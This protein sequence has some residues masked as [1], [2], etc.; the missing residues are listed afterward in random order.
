M[1][2]K[3]KKKLCL[4]RRKIS[5][6]REI[7]VMKAFI[8]LIV[9]SFIAATGVAQSDSLQK[10]INEQVWKPFITSYNNFDTDAFMAVHSKEL[11]R[12]LQD[13]DR[14]MNYAQYLESNKRGNDYGKS[15][16]DKRT[17]E[18]RFTERIAGE[19]RAFEVGYYKVVLNNNQAV[20]AKFQV[21]LR[22]E[23]GKWK[24][25]MDADANE[26]TMENTF[27]SGKPL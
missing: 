5:T 19:G 24:I 20:Y 1:F 22:V 9:A 26:K 4:K 11:T 17:I 8:L 25:L 21:L 7:P 14:V 10:Q 23:N 15:K 3:S 12:V 13:A 2:W 18:L 6:F 27:Q 16:N